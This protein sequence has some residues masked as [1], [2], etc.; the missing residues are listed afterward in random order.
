MPRK[1]PD[2]SKSTKK[3][4]GL[5]HHRGVAGIIEPTV[6][7]YIPGLTWEIAPCLVAVTVNTESTIGR[8]DLE[9][10]KDTIHFSMKVQNE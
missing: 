2:D 6:T 8:L 1:G 5:P 9:E 4:K 3:G 7:D 10:G